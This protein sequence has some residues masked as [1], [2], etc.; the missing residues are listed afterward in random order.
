[1]YYHIILTDHCNLSCSYCRGKLFLPSA[2]EEKGPDIDGDLPLEL[3]YDLEIL[4]RFLEKDPDASLIFYGGEPLL[5]PD[6]VS[7]MVEHA[8]V[9][10]FLVQ[11]NGLLL[12]RI[13]R[14]VVNRIDT[15]L[16][17]IDG[18][19]EITDGSRGEGTYDR[20]MANLQSIVSGGHQGEIIARMTVT[21]ETEIVRAVQ[22]LAGNPDFSFPSIHWQLD[23]D[24]ACDHGDRPFA[25]WVARS[26]N[27]GILTLIG[28]WVG[29]METEGVV[30][31][32]YPFIDPMEDLLTG[33]VSPLRCG[34]GHANLT[35]M[36]DG[37]IGP[38]PCMV[39]MRDFYLGH[40]RE[41]DP[42][43]LF[44]DPATGTF[45]S[46]TF[47]SSCSIRTFCGGRCLYA[48]VLHPWPGDMRRV[49]CGTV[50]NLYRGLSDALPRVR[51]L[52]DDGTIG[53]Q[54]FAHPR[55]N[56]CEIIP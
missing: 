53:M 38:C 34:A 16:V 31:R 47:C 28:D 15:I 44:I 33:R 19:R 35:I 24:L 27:P 55:Y 25:S 3:D 49:V 22:F 52:I 43:G 20:V 26:Y 21:E 14:H 51:G 8:P 37:S 12:D 1:M 48:Q 32:W 56:G 30:P 54:D 11:T 40:I 17:S 41:T 9:K 45:C 50:E 13:P 29:R 39:G 5:R 23:A 6:L 42:S 4:Y 2:P 10:R 46:S 7:E 18:P 36:T